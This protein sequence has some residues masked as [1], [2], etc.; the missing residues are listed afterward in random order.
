MI[1]IEGYSLQSIEGKRYN[2]STLVAFQL[3]TITRYTLHAIYTTLVV[4]EKT[5]EMNP[6]RKLIS[7]RIK[8]H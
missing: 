3:S 1:K 5:N 2:N 6:P 7:S 8:A 4:E